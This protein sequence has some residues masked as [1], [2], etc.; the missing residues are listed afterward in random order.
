MAFSSSQCCS[1][2]SIFGVC[3]VNPNGR[4][5]PFR[6]PQSPRPTPTACRFPHERMAAVGN[7]VAGSEWPILGRSRRS[8]HSGR[9]STEAAAT[10]PFLRL[11]QPVSGKRNRERISG[12]RHSQKA[13]GTA[14]DAAFPPL[15]PNRERCRSMVAYNQ[16]LDDVDYAPAT[17]SR[18]P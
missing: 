1:S 3:G 13:A 4:Y 9:P 7:D 2:A 12:K 5:P 11:H 18:L 8:R 10:F 16:S 6:A 15:V 17:C 14:G